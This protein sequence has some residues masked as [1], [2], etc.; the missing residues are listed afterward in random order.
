MNYFLVSQIDMVHLLS[1]GTLND[2]FTNDHEGGKGKLDLPGVGQF[3]IDMDRDKS[4]D[5]VDIEKT[6]GKIRS[7]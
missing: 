1:N 2:S 6:G 3:I 5:K 4:N 7:E